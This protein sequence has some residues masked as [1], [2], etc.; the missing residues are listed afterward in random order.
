MRE[1]PIDLSFSGLNFELFK[2]IVRAV[3][4]D[5]N[6]G[7]LMFL[8][9]VAPPSWILP[10]DVIVDVV[11]SATKPIIVTYSSTRS[12]YNEV[13]R[14]LEELGIP[15]YPSPERA[16]LVASMITTQRNIRP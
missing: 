7:L 14:R 16:A 5:K 13:K 6:V 12:D 10:V 3:S 11:K 4:E 1:N 2:R 15:V 8:Y 9:A